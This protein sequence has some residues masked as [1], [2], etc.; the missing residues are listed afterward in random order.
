MCTVTFVRNAGK[1]IITSNRDEQVVRKAVA[2]RSYTVGSKM[3]TFPKDPKAGGTW[4][5][6]DH[7]G[8]V[9]V[10]LNGAAE[11]HE[12]HP[13]YRRSRGLVVLD[14]LSAESPMATWRSMD[15]EGIEPFT[16]VL[17]V[18]GT[19]HQLRWDLA[20]K[21][22]IGLDPDAFHIW[23]STTLYPKEIRESRAKWFDI[24]TQNKT[25]LTPEDLF[26]FHRYT[27]PENTE[28]GLVIDR[29]GFLKTISITQAVIET[30]HVSMVHHDLVDQRDSV[31]S[32]AI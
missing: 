20:D 3:L 10:L 32:F 27:K 2:P 15:L 4:F 23:S 31:Q 25:Q 24:F 22:T 29:P 6:I 28:N 12:W 11:S 7:L 30:G 13:P 26:Y 21:E 14:I 5:A 8:N 9:L 18:D 16:I 19:L 1:T 17:F